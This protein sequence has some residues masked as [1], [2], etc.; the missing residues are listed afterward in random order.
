[1]SH[2][3]HNMLEQGVNEG[4]WSDRAELL[5]CVCRALERNCVRELR[6]KWRDC[7]CELIHTD[8]RYCI[9]CYCFFLQWIDMDIMWS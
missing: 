5:R 4:Q 8:V 2:K 1:M 6:E 7:Y 9:L 3:L